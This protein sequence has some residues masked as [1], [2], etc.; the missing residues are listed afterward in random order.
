MMNPEQ[1]DESLLINCRVTDLAYGMVC[2][3]LILSFNTACDEA[4]LDG[5]WDSMKSLTLEQVMGSCAPNGFRFVQNASF[6]IEASLEMAQDVA[7]AL[8]LM[9][10][11]Q[12]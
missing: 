1:I 4:E 12:L 10:A 5:D 11:G 9:K 8:E 6:E 3:D 7:A 2:A